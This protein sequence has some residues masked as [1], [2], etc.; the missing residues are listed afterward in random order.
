MLSLSHKKKVTALYVFCI[1]FAFAGAVIVTT[2]GLSMAGMLADDS[3]NEV[4]AAEQRVD[5]K[6]ITLQ[7]ALNHITHA[8]D[9]QD[10]ALWQQAIDDAEKR[11]ADALDKHI[12]DADARFQ[13]IEDDRAVSGDISSPKTGEEG[14]NEP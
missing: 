14:F 8:K 12:R 1:T 13:Q 6:L 4:Q 5:E 7:E 2:V 3:M 11:Q 9:A 10:E